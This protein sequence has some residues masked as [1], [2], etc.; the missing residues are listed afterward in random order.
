M[1]KNVFSLILLFCCMSVYQLAHALPI[2]WSYGQMVQVFNNTASTVT[3]YQVKLTVNTQALIS[4]GQMNPDGSDL[5]FSPDCD[6]TVLFNYWIESGINTTTTAI[7]VKMDV[8]AASSTTNMYMFYGNAGA[9]VSSAVVGTFFGPHSST[10][11]VASGGSGGVGN[12]QRGFR[13]TANEDLLVTAFGKRDP[14]GT[15]RYVTLFNYPAGTINTQT[16]VSGAAAQ[17][18]YSNLTNPIWLTQGAQYVLELFQGAG[19]GYYF[20]TSSQIGQHLTYGDMRFCNSCTQNTFPTSVLTNYH[21]GY[22]DLWYFTKTNIATLPTITYTDLTPT[23]S[24]SSTASGAV[25]SGTSVTL[26]ASGSGSGYTWTG[27]ISNGVP[28]NAS[29][30]QTYTV[31]SS[32]TCNVTAS[33]STTVNVNAA[34]TVTATATPDNLCL[35]SNTTLTGGGASSYLWTDGVNTPLDG[36]AFAPAA[37]TTYTVTGTDANLCT[38]TSSVTVTINPA[39]S[40]TVTNDDNCGPGVVNLGATSSASFIQ[41]YDALSGGNLLTTGTS[42]SPSIAST[43]SYYVQAQNTSAPATI[44]LP[45]QTG[46]FPGSVRGYWFTAPTDFIIT[47]VHVPTT[48]SSGNQSIAVVKFTGN[49]PPPL[50]SATTNAF[51]TAFLT[52][53]DP[54]PG[55][56]AVNIPVTAGEVIGIL[57]Y[58][59]TT[60]SYAATPTS[61]TIAGFSVPL[62]RMGMQFTLTTTAPQQLWTEAAGSI[63]RV[64]FD[65]VVPSGCVTNP[66]V[67]VTGTINTLPAVTASATPS[68]ICA[69]NTTD[70]S[71]GG[72]NSYVWDNGPMTAN[73]TAMPNVTTTYTVTGTDA[74]T[75]TATS[76]VQVSVGALSTGIAASTG[77]NTNNQPDGTSIN[78]TNASCELIANVNDGAGGNILGNTLATVTVSGST[79]FYNGQPYLRRWYEITPANNGAATVTLYLNQSDFDDYNSNNGAYPDLPTSGNNSDPNIPNIRITKVDGTLGSGTPTVITPTMNWN[80]SYWEATFGVNGFSQ[81]FFHGVNPGNIPLPATLASFNGKKLET[82][83][84]LTWSTLNEQ[85]NSHFNL[86]YSQDGTNFST[87]AKLYSKAAQGNSSMPLNYSFEHLQPQTGHNYYRLQQTDIDGHSSLYAQVIDLIWNADGSMVN[88]YPNP[89]ED[90]LNIDLQAVKAQHT[91]IK[92]LDMSG[93]VI[94]QVQAR[95]ESGLNHMVIN[96]EGLA[97]GIYSVQVMGNDHMIY[98]GK[99]SKQ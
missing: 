55:P 12:S 90:L 96:M 15:T 97:Q 86:Q 24:I 33:A 57:G 3:D 85:N 99:V 73:Q 92:V 35:G 45:A 60:N 10:D 27:G 81:F 59:G 68:V 6:G 84:W 63:S 8:L 40:V 77:N 65:Y 80:G 53:N 72:A 1:K 7:W 71:A 56:I 37:T 49:V 21:Y 23:V 51:T 69:G 70:L 20:G 32:G 29:S 4:A 16:Q 42:Y 36:V 91:T 19:D 38:A 58:R 95:T 93:R 22:P 61:T 44:P 47:N 25:C 46:T 14:N 88:I 89:A 78:Y 74:N 39:P 75:C 64:E 17:Y 79:L 41:W 18:S 83:D 34:P 30:T 87:I 50:Y 76:T 98:T 43:T 66:R 62:A 82:S 5:R 13:F 9:A 11:S 26:T 48:A 54:T 67:Q 28:F 52:Q 94:R 2:G 31:T